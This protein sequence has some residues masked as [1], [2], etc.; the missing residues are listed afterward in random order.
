MSGKKVKNI[1][2]HHSMICFSHATIDK[3]KAKTKEV[4]GFDYNSFVDSAGSFPIHGII[5]KDSKE[6][7]IFPFVVLYKKKHIRT[8][9]VLDTGS[10]WTFLSAETFRDLGIYDVP[11]EGGL[12]LA[13]QGLPI[14]VYLSVNHFSDINLCGQSFFDEHKLQLHVNYRLRKLII[15]ETDELTLEELQEL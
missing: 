12:N 8:A 1:K 14:T 3:M 11:V 2:R 15:D 9:C 5:V 6:R 13:L 7:L 4:F 10:P